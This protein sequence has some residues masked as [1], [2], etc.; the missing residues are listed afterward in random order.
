MYQTTETRRQEKKHSTS[1][2][3]INGNENSGVNLFRARALLSR[4]PCPRL[5]AA[6]GVPPVGLVYAKLSSAMILLYMLYMMELGNRVFTL[7]LLHVSVLVGYEYSC[8]R[9][10]YL[11][12][13][14]VYVCV[15][16]GTCSRVYPRTA[17]GFTPYVV[18]FTLA[19]YPIIGADHGRAT[20]PPLFFWL[21]VLEHYRRKSAIRYFLEVM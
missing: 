4:L 14:H 15:A 2:E 21:D 9:Y 3:T 19:N 12:E 8:S 20:L 5:R 10:Y 16:R 1:L 17:V 7:Y 6:V 11:T 18:V 13:L